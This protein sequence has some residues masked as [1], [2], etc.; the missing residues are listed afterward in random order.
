MSSTTGLTAGRRAGAT[1][2]GLP[3]VGRQP[4][5]TQVLGGQL[6]RHDVDEHAG[7]PLEPG[8]GGDERQDVD[9]PVEGDVVVVRGAVEDHVV[10]DVAEHV[11]EAGEHVAHGPAD[12]D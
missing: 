5:L 10:G 11:P 1:P 2:V 7:A 9:V 6:R 12:A 4:T 3:D 8:P